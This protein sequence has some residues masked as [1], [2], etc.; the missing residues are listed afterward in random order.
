[1][2]AFREIPGN[3]LGVSDVQV[4]AVRAEVDDRRAVTGQEQ[5]LTLVSVPLAAVDAQLRSV[6]DVKVGLQVVGAGVG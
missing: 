5:G 4:A 6:L 3:D 1:M 2:I